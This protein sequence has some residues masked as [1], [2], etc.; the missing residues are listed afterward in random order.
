MGTLADYKIASYVMQ[1]INHVVQLKTKAGK[2][3]SFCSAE[4]QLPDGSWKDIIENDS[5]QKA[6]LCT[7][8][9]ERMRI[10]K[11]AV[12]DSLPVGWR[13]GYFR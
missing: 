9:L 10:L 5:V 6:R 8:C 7:T 1:G 12:E 13:E 3:K 4:F 2:Y 11:I